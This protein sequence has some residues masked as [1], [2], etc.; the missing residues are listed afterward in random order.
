MQLWMRE[1][2]RLCDVIETMP[3]LASKAP[4]AKFNIDK[5]VVTA[6]LHQITVTGFL[7]ALGITQADLEASTGKI[8][9]SLV[10]A[11]FSIAYRLGHT[12][13]P[14]NVGNIDIASLFDGQVRPLPPPSTVSL[15]A[16]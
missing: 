7:P 9:G 12:M 14:D 10:S 13:I 8:G 2:N 16:G 3:A 15:G 6:K 5:A 11:E 4:G 1:H